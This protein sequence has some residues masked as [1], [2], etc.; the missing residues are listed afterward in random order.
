MTYKLIET[1][2]LEKSETEVTIEIDAKKFESYRASAMKEIQ[3]HI[4]LPGFRKG[5]VPENMIENQVAEAAILEEM[6]EK[7]INDV[8][9]KVLDDEKIDAI[10]RPEISITKIAKG[11]PLEFKVKVAIVPEVKLPK[12]KE[13]AKKEGSKKEKVTVEDKEVEDTIEEIRKSR[14]KKIEVETKDEKGEAKIE[15]KMDLHDLDDEFVK[16]LGDFKNVEE[17]KTK[18]KENIGLEK[19]RLENDKNRTRIIEEIVKE[20]EIELPN[21]I[22]EQELNKMLAQF[23]GNIESMGLNFDEYLKRSEKGLDE[24]KKEWEKDAEKRAKIQFMIVKIAEA[25]KIKAD[26]KEID[27]EVG[28]LVEHYADID[29]ARARIYVESMLTNEKVM[30]FLEEQS[31]LSK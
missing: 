25:E 12:Y 11:N 3:K 8:Y 2:K 13:I 17:L 7:A 9:G 4:E 30:K 6:A 16:T 20:T 23:R 5:K 19:E 24:I 14:G 28:H 1:K 18:I 10:G 22:V 26:E 15:E 27:K 31:S 29:P 21:I